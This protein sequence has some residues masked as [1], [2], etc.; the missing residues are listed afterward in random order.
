MEETIAELKEIRGETET[1]SLPTQ[2]QIAAIERH[3]SAYSGS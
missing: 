2:E 1:I 3:L